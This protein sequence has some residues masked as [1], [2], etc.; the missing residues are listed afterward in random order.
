MTPVPNR[1]ENPFIVLLLIFLAD[2][3]FQA[4]VLGLGNIGFKFS[5]DEKREGT[6]SHVDAYGKCPSTDLIAAVEIDKTTI[7][8]FHTRYPGIPVY[9]TVEALFAAHNLDIVS[10][11]VPT[12]LHY[13]MFKE[14]SQYP[15]KAIFCE[16]PLSLSVEESREMV[17][18][19]QEKDILL[20]V[21]YTRRWQNSYIFVKKL[22]DEGKIGKITAI[23]A[24]YPGQIYN[25]GSHLFDTVRMISGLQPVTASVIKV[26]DA[27]DPS[28]SGWFL[29]E[30][31]VFFSFIAT[32]NREDLIFEIDVVGCQGR[33]R[34]LE[35]GDKV[36]YYVFQESKR[37]SSYR[38]LV[39]VHITQ[40]LPNDRFADA[41]QNIADVLIGSAPC[42]YCSGTD[43]LYVDMMIAMVLREFSFPLR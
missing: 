21:N 38:E 9:P 15:V 24:Y 33:I 16:K 14:V 39:P 27:P 6:W 40:P 13:P 3:V 36:E 23:T 8:L 5:Y 19:A 17:R 41:V 42:I 25:I 43:G 30:D 2:M 37:Y 28:V 22:I 4:A 29:S 31:K 32:G 26:N 35:N 11:C 1:R 34:I 20:A 18:I 7:D 12:K 10:L